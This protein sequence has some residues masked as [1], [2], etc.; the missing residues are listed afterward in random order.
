MNANWIRYFQGGL[1][2][3]EEAFITFLLLFVFFLR[4]SGNKFEMFYLKISTAM[5]LNLFNE[6]YT[7]IKE[8]KVTDS[9]VTSDITISKGDGKFNYKYKTCV[10]I[11][12]TINIIAVYFYF[13]DVFVPGWLFHC[14]FI[15][16]FTIRRWIVF[17]STINFFLLSI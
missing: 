5:N 12:V 6:N 16:H 13:V 1:E 17:H 15:S 4:P 11:V 3:E 7:R 14:D 9:F 10:T 2:R 8:K